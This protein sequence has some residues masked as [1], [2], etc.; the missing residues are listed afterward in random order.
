MNQST[1]LNSKVAAAREKHFPMDLGKGV[2]A[3]LSNREAVY[4]L[5]AEHSPSVFPKLSL[6]ARFQLPEDR[7]KTAGLLSDSFIASGHKDW[8][9]VLKDQLP[10]GWFM[11]NI[12]QTVS[13]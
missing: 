1:H 11:K 10:I 4:K 5:F 6:C 13:G 3:V 2:T 12:I 8:I 9:V 7:Q